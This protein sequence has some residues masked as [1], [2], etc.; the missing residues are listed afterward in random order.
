MAAIGRD[1]HEG[2]RHEAGDDA[3]LAGHLCADLAVGGQPVGGAQ[4]VVEGEVELELTRR[5]LVV[6]LD[7]VEAH[8]AAIFD[9]PQID[10]S[11][12]LEL[13]D[14]IAVR[15]RVAA[16][17]LAV[18]VLL[19]P[20]HLG[21][22][23]VP[24]LQP[25]VLLELLVDAAEIAAGVRREEGARLPALL[26]VAEQRAPEPRHALVPGELHEGLGLGNA[27]QLGRFGA[28]AKIVA[29]P[30]EEEVH[31]GAV[32]EL[33]ALPRD[34][35][36]MVG[37]DALAH[38]AAGDRHELQ[39]EVLDAELVDLAADLFDKLLALRIVDEALDIRQSTCLWMQLRSCHTSTVSSTGMD[40]GRS[41]AAR[42]W[43]SGRSGTAPAACSS[44]PSTLA[45]RACPRRSSCSRDWSRR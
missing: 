27:D 2:L 20:H 41:G 16:V 12:A 32:D 18:L 33:E 21:L 44:L 37:R 4:R 23:A 34:A 30:V 10:G 43:R 25:V 24:Q 13:V 15:I 35:L 28:I 38:D 1:A 36:P 39:I 40:Y 31:G 14:V 22:G 6:A 8:L 3:E 5:I 26:A 9:D 19:Q 29:V 7:H 17:R 45:P 42:P 11:Q